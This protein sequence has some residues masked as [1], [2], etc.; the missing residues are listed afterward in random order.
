MELTSVRRGSPNAWTHSLSLRCGTGLKPHQER[1]HLENNN[2]NN[3]AVVDDND[4]CDHIAAAENDDSATEKED[5]I[6]SV[7]PAK[8]GNVPS[9]AS[10]VGS[11]VDN[12]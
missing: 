5:R 1:F 2:N 8:R 7:F 11:P 12:T 9:F 10:N 6:R 3:N 4:G